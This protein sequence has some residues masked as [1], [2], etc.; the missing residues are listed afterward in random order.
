MSSDVDFSQL[1]E[2]SKKQNADTPP[3]TKTKKV[4]FA[5][6]TWIHTSYLPPGPALSRCSCIGPR[7]MVFG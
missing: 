1:M 3:D 2:D 6:R 4:K 5:V 7:A